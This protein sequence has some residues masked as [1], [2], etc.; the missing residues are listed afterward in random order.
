MAQIR[1]EER[2]PRRDARLPERMRAPLQLFV[3]PK[4]RRDIMTIPN[5]LPGFGQSRM[6]AAPPPS[7]PTPSTP[8][9]EDPREHEPIHDPPIEPEHDADEGVV[10]QAAGGPKLLVDSRV[11]DIPTE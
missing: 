7:A 2:S 9:P 1:L 5:M 10:R 3:W 8:T 6:S 4:S 11:S